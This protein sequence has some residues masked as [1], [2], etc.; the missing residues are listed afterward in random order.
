MATPIGSY[1]D[2]INWNG[3]GSAYLTAGITIDNASYSSTTIPFTLGSGQTFDGKGYTITLSNGASNFMGLFNLQGGTIQHLRFN[4]ASASLQNNAGWLSYANGLKTTNGACGIIYNVY[5]NPSGLPMGSNCGGFVGIYAANQSNGSSFVTGSAS[6]NLSIVDCRYNGRFS[7]G[8]GGIL[9]KFPCNITDAADG[10][11]GGGV[12]TIQN[13]FVNIVASDTNG[14]GIAG[15]YMAK[16]YT[17]AN[18]VINRCIVTGT[19]NTNSTGGFVGIGSY[20]DITNSYSLY[21]I[22]SK[23]NSGGFYHKDV[24]GTITT[25]F[26]LAA[27]TGTGSGTFISKES[28]GTSRL[29]I[30]SCA[31][32][33]TSFGDDTDP[34]ITKSS[35]CLTLYTT[36][37][38]NSTEPI[39]SFNSVIWDKTTQPPTLSAFKNSAKWSS[40]TSYNITPLIIFSNDSFAVGDPHINSLNGELYDLNICGFFKLF[41]NNDLHNRLIINGSIEKGDGPF[42]KMKYIRN[43]YVNYN[44]KKMLINMGFRG[45]PV[46][47]MYNDGIEITETSL[48]F[49]NETIFCDN[50]GFKTKDIINNK[51]VVQGHNISPLIRNKLE[52]IIMVPHDNLYQITLINVGEDNTNPCQIMINPLINNTAQLNKYD[53]AYVRKSNIE[54]IILTQI[55]EIITLKKMIF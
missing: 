37:T 46:K 48:C 35:D 7:S 41:D 11:N 24:S 29:T 14:S 50:C 51:H 23:Q 55:D 27:V 49:S 13:C 28:F 43:I 3:S 38:S 18:N 31:T 40:Y 20:C 8:G 54:D 16:N 53:G 6:N 52:F 32:S 19:P 5:V 33:G 42:R 4:I 15:T 36:G 39:N 2:F 26:F 12:I 44:N 1:S 47:V 22:S 17:G 30:V 21:N 9:G 34:Y 25:S 45:K 10:T